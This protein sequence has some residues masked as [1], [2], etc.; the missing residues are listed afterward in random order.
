MNA[1]IERVARALYDAQSDDGDWLMHESGGPVRTEYR[2]MARAAIEALREPTN[3]MCFVNGPGDQ[4][5]YA[6]A[7]ARETWRKMIDAALN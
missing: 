5:N 2:A 3:A 6:D 1:M 4:H 7:A